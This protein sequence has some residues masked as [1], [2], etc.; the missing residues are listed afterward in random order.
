MKPSGGEV[1]KQWGVSMIAKGE[2]PSRYQE[3]M[4]R[5]KQTNLPP[6]AP[7]IY[8]LT[9]SGGDR[10]AWAV[11]NVTNLSVVVKRSQK[12]VLTWVTD[13]KTGRPIRGAEVTLYENSG[14]QVKSGETG[15]DGVFILQ[16]P[17]RENQTII[18]TRGRDLA[19]V[20]CG[21]TN[22]D[23]QL[24]VHFQTDR[25]IYRPG[26]TVMFKA[27][28]RH[29]KGRG[30][31]PLANKTC[32]VQA[33]DSK[34][35]AFYDK[36]LTTNAIGSLSGEVRLASEGSLG[37]YSIVVA[38]GE[39]EAYH[40]FDVAEYRKP[41]FKVDVSPGAKRYLAGQEIVFNV[42]ASYYFGAP[43]PQAQVH[44]QVRRANNF[45]YGSRD[46]TGDWYAD[47]SGNMDES[48]VYRS[49]QFIAEGTVY[50]DKD[51]KVSIPIKTDKAAPDSIYRI[52]C[53]T[54]DTSRRQVE[55]SAGAPAYSAE[56]R[57]GISTDVLVAP[58]GS[59]IPIQLRAV[60]L[61]GKPAAAKVTVAVGKLVWDEKEHRYKREELT[62]TRV[63]IP[64]S[65]KA[66]ARV[67]AKAAGNLSILATAL[68]RTGR[69]ASAQLTVW[70]AGPSAKFEKEEQ[71][72]VLTLKPDRRSYEPG[73]TTGIWVNSNTPRP[74]LL[75]VSG[76][77]IFEY[78]VLPA[79][80][81]SFLWK[82]KTSVEM[83][84]N[85]YAEAEQWSKSYRVS[86]NALLPIPDRTRKLTVSVEPDK[87]AYRPGDTA[88]WTVRTK[89]LNGKPIPAEASVSV[90]D[91]SIYA[92]KP[93]NTRDPYAQFW[94][95]RENGVATNSSAPEEMSGG[96][97]QGAPETGRSALLPAFRSALPP[98]A[99]LAGVRQR[100]L[101]TAYWNANLM[102]DMDGTATVS[103][104]VPGNLT[105]WRGKALA[106]TG[107]TK[108]GKAQTNVQASRPVM[109][110]LAVPRQMVQ[111]DTL[112][113]I[114]TI[115]NRADRAH[116]FHVE[117]AA[118]GLTIEGSPARKVNVPAKGEAT[119]EW[120][121]GAPT[122]PES[123]EAS[124]T[125]ALFATDVPAGS[126]EEMSDALK[127]N[128]RIAPKGI[129]RRILVGG[130]LQNEKTVT[131]DLPEDRIEPASRVT[132][133][134]RAGLKQVADD[135]AREVL[136]SGRY[137][138][139]AAA[140][141]LLAA[142][143]VGAA[144]A[145]E[146]VRESLA[147][148][149]RYQQGSGAWGWWETDAWDPVTTA[150]VL[151]ALARA[152]AARITVP[153]DLLARG[154]SGADLLYGQTNL[155]EHKALLASAITLAEFAVS[156]SGIAEGVY[157]RRDRLLDEVHR[158]G[159]DLSP[160]ARMALAEAYAKAS[161]M[162][163]AKEAIQSVLKDAVDGPDTAYLPVGDKPGW[164]ATTVEAT[165]RALTVLAATSQGD[166]LQA[167]LAEWLA[168]P[169]DYTWL[170]N[171]EQAE[172]AF[173]LAA[174]LKK[175]PQPAQPGKPEIKVNGAAVE[176]EEESGKPVRAS[177]PRS[178][179]KSGAN[180]ISLTRTGGG[181]VFFSVEARVHRPAEQESSIGMRL[182]RRYES[183]NDAGVWQELAGS[184]KPSSPV[185]CT[186]LVW[187]DDKP[188]GI[189][190]VE[191]IPAGFE[192]VDSD[193]NG[194]WAREEV[195]DAAVIHYMRSFGEPIYFRYYLR[196]ESEGVVTALPASAEIIRRP[197]VSGNTA[198]STVQVKK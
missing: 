183:Q 59:L 62:R 3:D 170:S 18:V 56:I 132:I 179:L 182:L 48:D 185:R 12:R 79:N 40:S 173:A 128:L 107:D 30:Y 168:R 27:I 5:G 155:W 51:G 115:N 121:I 16:T 147:L 58:L 189:R 47:W 41:E 122:L 190:V 141:Q 102:T 139:S 55:A 176:Y 38:V 11:V 85:A 22:T 32:S 113:L 166:E 29:T 174:Y 100:F 89:A 43:L 68:D 112:R 160:Y 120:T 84:P 156:P 138:T 46:E 188:D 172:A 77:D 108:T 154:I 13:A 60:D 36:K 118:E 101:D 193:R 2:R 178:L 117:L 135:L 63:T 198:T 45:Y 106:I 42:A 161:K 142:C 24:V 167:K 69:K 143:V 148:L 72:P 70:T 61:D 153:D 9:A 64:A 103:F 33:R 124:I 86:A 4:Y 177:V 109:L 175:H 130:A 105:S 126:V 116:E 180:T 164:S 39:V 91:E 152:R 187:P 26:Q 146:D 157:I 137:S 123:G 110:R 171:D 73:R 81:K 23:G 163:W 6:L 97:F 10:E 35:N 136:D 67:P 133:T 92:I 25:P 52:K 83:S 88:V 53:T 96:A 195:R 80:T 75:T 14:K 76:L 34:D 95:I 31:V 50:T 114:G 191:P 19:A 17:P 93:D 158:R 21:A 129:E 144:N 99:K 192:F 104:D 37:S 127:V 125:G 57:L 8:V 65:G 28:L 94:G 159:A 196:A 7:G 82:V 44:Y 71:G 54:T 151:T 162:D 66:A 150:R 131:L 145:S 197:A 181:S 90:V 87:K 20:P 49:D 74:V 98:G 165:A 1:V 169:D 111:G 15:P 186:V 194:A 149:S 119:V 140:D 78:L 184:L 134:V